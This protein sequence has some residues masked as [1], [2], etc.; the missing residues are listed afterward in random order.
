MLPTQHDDD[1][2]NNKQTPPDLPGVP[3]YLLTKDGKHSN[4]D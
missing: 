2:N 4:R 3:P 1:D